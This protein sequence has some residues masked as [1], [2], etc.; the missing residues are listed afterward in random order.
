[1]RLESIGE[2]VA[3]GAE[4]GSPAPINTTASAVPPLRGDCR[5]TTENLALDIRVAEE[6]AHGWDR[7]GAV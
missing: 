7:R 3:S 5:A 1:M 4:T 2:V 6:F